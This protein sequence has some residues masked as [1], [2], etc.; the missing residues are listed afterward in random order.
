M[1]LAAV[2]LPPTAMYP[3]LFALAALVSATFLIAAVSGDSPPDPSPS[4]EWTP[5]EVVR[6]QVEALQRNDQPYDDAGIETAFEFA[7]PGNQAATGP[8]P[9]F[10]EMVHG[11]VYRD[12]LGF[13]SAEYGPIRVEGDQAVQDVTL[14]QADGRRVTFLFGLSRQSDGACD[15]CWMT[16][17]VVRQDAPSDGTTRV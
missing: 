17:A 4:P 10:A 15:G 9:R 16:D 11:P 13:K 1:R 3:S 8:L 6:F 12:M 5:A 2:S 14:V 7:S